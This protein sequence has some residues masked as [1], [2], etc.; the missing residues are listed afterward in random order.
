MAVLLAGGGFPRGSVYGATDKHGMAPVHEPC[1]PDDV[2][3]T[4]FQALGIGP[5][6]EVQT[7]TGRPIALFREGKVL[8]NILTF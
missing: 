5:Q 7:L 2:S 1:S 4:I 3:A 6:S 8:R